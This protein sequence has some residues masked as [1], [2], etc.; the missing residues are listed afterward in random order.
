MF[1][2]MIGWI[3]LLFWQKM[4]GA[5]IRVQVKQVQSLY[6]FRAIFHKYHISFFMQS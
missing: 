5:S 3:E 2:D 4:S 1:V 6:Q